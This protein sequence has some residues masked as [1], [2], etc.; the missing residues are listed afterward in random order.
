MGVKENIMPRTA[1]IFITLFLFAAL[2]GCAPKIAPPGKAPAGT[3]S[4][5]A[6]VTESSAIKRGKQLAVTKC[7][8]CHR[9]Y[10]PKEYSPNEWDMI[11]EQKRNRLSLTQSQVDSLAAFLKKSDL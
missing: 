3:L 7:I 4:P 5:T 10:F 11:I 9:F 8:A 1:F 6:E 2:A